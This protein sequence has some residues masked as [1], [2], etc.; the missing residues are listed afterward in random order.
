MHSQLFSRSKTFPEARIHSPLRFLHT[1]T[2][3]S[4]VRVLAAMGIC[5]AIASMFL[6]QGVPSVFAVQAKVFTN[7]SFYMNS[8]STSTAYNLGCNQ[9]GSDA[10][11][12]DNS[13]VVLDF[14]GQ[15]SNGSGSLMINGVSITNSQI[16]A[17]TENFS[18][19]YWTCARNDG[20][21]TTILD[22]GIGTNNSYQ[23]VSQAGG[24]AWINVVSVVQN[25]NK[26]QGYYAQV[27][28]YAA[29]DMEPGFGS[30]AATI[31]WVHGVT[32]I[33]GLD[34]L[35]YGSADGC[36]QTSSSNGACNNGW[37]Q[38][39][40]WYVSNGPTQGH[41]IP[42][43]YYPAQASQWA[44]LSLYGAQHQGRRMNI[45][46]PWDEYDLDHSTYTAAQAWNQLWTDVNNNSATKQNFSYSMEIH[47]E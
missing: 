15:L 11:H 47:N 23:D 20:D 44:M 28:M 19:G 41:P 40:V 26:A 10:T 31:N 46:G 39:D 30:A 36:P 43:I 21:T 5:A 38:Y 3:R 13:V 24:A 29:N 2:T 8:A 6:I 12:H 32:S 25:Y 18:K 33:S 22:L 14:G 27:K 17:A 35:N 1:L 9:G 34:Y 45:W 4:G 16:E 7:W 37:N 42:E